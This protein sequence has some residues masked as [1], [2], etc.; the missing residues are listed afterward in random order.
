MKRG[1]KYI[2]SQDVV[3]DRELVNLDSA[4]ALVKESS[5]TTFVGSVDLHI[6]MNIKDEDPKS[7]K[8]SVS[9]PNMET[10]IIRIAVA[11]SEDEQKLA[12]DSGADITSFDTL[13]AD[14][15]AGKIEFDTLIATPKIMPK[16]AV[17]GKELGPKGLM[18]NPKNGTIVMP[19]RLKTTVDE[20]RKGRVVFK[21]DDAGNIHI[22]VGKINM[23]DAKIKENILAVLQAVASVIGKSK[24]AF[25]KKLY[26]SPTM[27]KAIAID[28]KSI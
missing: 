28:L 23:E 13:V 21:A 19:D 27:G 16:L 12:D 22:S 9:L 8:G 20:F 15:K 11:V 7:I 24:E 4:I 18:P 14:V 1:K 5:Y 2:K 25:V 26:L 6:V 17:L 3:K 10:R